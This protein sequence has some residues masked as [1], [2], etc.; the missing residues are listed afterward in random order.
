M[1][2]MITTAFA[3]RG[4]SR[5]LT[6]ARFRA[7]VLVFGALSIA[8]CKRHDSAESAS[9]PSASSTPSSTA[10]VPPPLSAIASLAS[11]IAG[12][13]LRVEARRGSIASAE[14]FVDRQRAVLE[15]HFG[16]A[17]P[18]PLEYQVVPVTGGRTAV[19]FEASQG[20]ARPIVFLLDGAHNPIWTKERAMGGVKPGV[21]EAALASGPDGHVCLAWCNAST[22]SVA[23]RRWADDG[24]AFA[25]YDALHVD[26]CDKLS[27]FYWPR[28]GWV[29]AAAGPDGALAERVTE[30]GELAWGR[31]GLRL[32]WT[33]SG[34]APLAIAADT[35]DTLLFFRIG[36]SGAAG[37]GTYLF[38]TRWDRGGRPLW[39][40]PVAAKRIDGA[41]RPPAV[42]PVLSPGDGVIVAQLP[43]GA[44]EGGG[45]ILV[46]VA[47]D[48][49]VTRR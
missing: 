19:L 42:R 12:A 24:G 3:A 4:S 48:G 28:Y 30:N 2:T 14:P 6:R 38:A 33:W 15:A 49:T 39:P 47:S 9:A 36:Q 1:S 22:D 37:S 16:G 11:A 45:A 27:I 25:D 20:D 31:D 13:D 44:V 35:P 41:V 43:D 5:F 7:S 23:L 21:S 18:Y 40:G 10:V 26:A 8:S 34:P 17:V 29:I 46:D 32:P